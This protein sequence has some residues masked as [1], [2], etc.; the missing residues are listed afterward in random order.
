MFYDPVFAQ[1]S[2]RPLIFL[3]IVVQ[4]F[5]LQLDLQVPTFPLFVKFPIELWGTNK[6]SLTLQK[7]SKKYTNSTKVKYQIHNHGVTI[8]LCF[9]GFTLKATGGVASSPPQFKFNFR[10]LGTN[11]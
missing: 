9:E 2:L 1:L 10:N 11:E 8:V 5:L 4:R 6:G 7:L 3:A